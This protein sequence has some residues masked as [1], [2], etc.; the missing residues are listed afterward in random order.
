MTVIEAIKEGFKVTNQNKKLILIVFCVSLFFSF[1]SIFLFPAIPQEKVIKIGPSVLICIAALVEIFIDG[2]IRG[3]V[4]DILLKVKY[5]GNTFFFY[6][7]KYFFRL[8][9]LGILIG[10]IWIVIS[11][12]LP[13]IM[14]SAFM[15]SGSMGTIVISIITV[16]AVI[17]GLFLLLFILRLLFILFFAYTTIVIEN[18]KIFS[19]ITESF[20]FFKKYIHKV[21]GILFIFLGISGVIEWGSKKITQFETISQAVNYGVAVVQCSLKA[22]LTIIIIAACMT[23]YLALREKPFPEKS[24]E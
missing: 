21:Q 9:S 4:K 16:V 22:Y 1:L 18:S 10:V 7:G 17:L 14:A 24:G 11:C 3:S 13:L 12:C 5:Q 6:C 15:L 19:G 2:G 8:L 20:K 23:L